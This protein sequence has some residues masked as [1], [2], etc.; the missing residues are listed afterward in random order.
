MLQKAIFILAFSVLLLG[1]QAKK[2]S[3]PP[4]EMI[5]PA[6]SAPSIVEEPLQRADLAVSDIA[7]DETGRVVATLSNYGRGVVPPGSGELKIYV[8]GELK[9]NISLDDIPDRAFLVPGATT[10]Y[11]APVEVDGTHEVR[12]LIES[13]K[14]MPENEERNKVMT[15][16]LIFEREVQSS[17]PPPPPLPALSPQEPEVRKEIPLRPDVVLTDLSLNAK[18]RLVVHLSNNGDA[19]FLLEQGSLK[20][21]VDNV[22]K[23]SYGLGGLSERR[24]LPPK[25]EAAFDTSIRIMGRH[26]VY[27]HLEI[28][29]E[30][31]EGDRESKSV[32]KILESVP[33]GPDIIVKDLVLTEDLELSIVLSNA[34]ETEL[35]RGTTLRIRVMLNDRRVSEFDH[36][37]TEPLRPGSESRYIVEPPYRVSVGGNARVKVTIW[38]KQAGDDIRPG[39]NT[40]ERDFVIFPFRIDPQMTQEF[41]FFPPSLLTKDSSPGPSIKTEVRW[42]GG[43]APLRLSLKREGDLRKLAQVSGKS[44]LEL[45]FP[46]GEEKDSTGKAWRFLITNLMGRTVEGHL[47]V[48]S[49]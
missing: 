11:S 23:G 38:P 18:R 31:D 4:P 37:I 45:E 15:K 41:A 12:A 43:G 47:I 40:L 25:E 34:G 29:P 36:L 10:R 26:E 39:N 30:A 16:T 24:S 20:I 32:R 1:C 14:A 5:P 46:A 35:R 48:Q 22:L 21:F 49:P 7:L 33:I 2:V 27:V 44:P 8:D 13:D 6:V 17:S 42:D 28:S 9:W 19:P 3:L